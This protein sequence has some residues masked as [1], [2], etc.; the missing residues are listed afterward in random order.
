MKKAKLLTYFAIASLLFN[1][2]GPLVSGQAAA[3][4]P[5]PPMPAPDN[6]GWNEESNSA[7]PNEMP[8]D[9]PCLAGASTTENSIAHNWDPVVYPGNIW[10]QRQVTAPGGAVYDFYT[11][12][13]FTGFS[14][15]GGNPG[16]FGTWITK[17]RAFDDTNTNGTLDDSETRSNWSQLCPILYE[18]GSE[19]GSGKIVAEKFEDLNDNGLRDAGEPALAGWEMQL[20][21]G[22]SLLKTKTTGDKGKAKFRNLDAGTY[23]VK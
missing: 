17:V 1:T 15:F 23:T 9:I 12:D 5:D 6:L 2:V 4:P 18:E 20:W 16:K 13:T 21:Q 10:Y 22:D 8:L 3:T 7:T 19:P 11:S 14:T